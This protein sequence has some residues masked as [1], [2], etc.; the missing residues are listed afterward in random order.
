MINANCTGR[1]YNVRVLINYRDEKPDDVIDCELFDAGSKYLVC[2]P[3]AGDVV[4]IKRSRVRD[5]LIF[6]VERNG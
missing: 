6:A 3:F 4:V 1:L 5:F 2:W